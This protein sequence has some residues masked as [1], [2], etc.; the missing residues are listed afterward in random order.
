MAL[1]PEEMSN[2]YKEVSDLEE[3]GFVRILDD[4]LVLTAKGRPLLNAVAERLLA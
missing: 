1:F 4:R 2:F 3:S